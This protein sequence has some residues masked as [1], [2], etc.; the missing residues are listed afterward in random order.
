MTSVTTSINCARPQLQR[1]VA[2]GALAALG[3][4]C[5]LF[6]ADAFV[7]RAS[8]VVAG[9]VF[10]IAGLA[11]PGPGG[12]IAVL[13]F[14][15]EGFALA[16]LPWQVVMAAAL[17]LL[18]ATS[19]ARTA[20]PS[21]WVPRGRVPRWSTFACAAITPA[22]LVGW[23]RLLKPDVNDITRLVPNL[24]L[25]WL[26]AGGVAFAIVNA[27]FEEW[28]WRG[29]FQTFTAELFPLSVAIGVQAVSFG[30]AHAHGFPRGVLGVV[31][32]GTWAILLG[33]LRTYSR[34]LLAP[35]LA[36]IVADLT[37]ALLVIF[38]LR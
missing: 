6:T 5:V 24:A 1:A 8:P 2:L 31:L 9:A 29:L 7:V 30:I 26:V 23:T 18:L 32:A 28:I 35:V 37:I 20:M 27:L 3:V 22:F 15:I 25:F 34:G 33:V 16:K 12:A 17:T 36:H 38:W 13:A 4:A 21:V 11:W 14:A 19:R 10:A